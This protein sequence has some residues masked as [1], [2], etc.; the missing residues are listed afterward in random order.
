MYIYTFIYMYDIVVQVTIYY[1]VYAMTSSHNIVKSYTNITPLFRF[2]VQK[3]LA[4]GCSR[5]V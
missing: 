3:T 2:K 1:S 4:K 5:L